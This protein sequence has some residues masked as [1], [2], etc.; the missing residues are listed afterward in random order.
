MQ[1]SSTVNSAVATAPS[2][3]A[4]EAFAR[5]LLSLTRNGRVYPRGHPF[6]L[7]L[8]ER[9]LAGVARDLPAPLDVGITNGEL[10]VAGQFF[11]GAGTRAGQ[12]AGL[13]HGCKLLRMVWSV[14]ATAADVEGLAAVLARDDL[15]AGQVCDTLLEAGVHTIALEPLALERI[16]GA[17][18]P[19]ES[20]S[21]PLAVDGATR[22]REAWQW[23]LHDDATPEQL[24]AKA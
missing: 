13:L 1:P 23:L 17:F 9:L 16:H 20:S 21:G 15:Q 3:R 14:G 19:G 22:A 4:V 11:G 7:Q 10:V 8:C 2:L 18:R 5:D 12:L 6:L 24:M